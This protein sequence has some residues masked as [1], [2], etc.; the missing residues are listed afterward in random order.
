MNFVNLP[1]IYG[2]DE[3]HWM[4]IWEANDAS[5]LRFEPG[6]WAEPDLHDW[7]A[8][9]DKA[10]KSPDTVLVAHS[11][12]CLLVSHWADRFQTPVRGAILVG[13]PDPDGPNFPKAAS[14][15]KSPPCKTFSFPTMGLVS[16]NDH[17]GSTRFNE[18]VRSKW[19]VPL[20]ELGALGHMNEDS[21]LGSWSQG[22]QLVKAFAAGTTRDE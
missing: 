16:S 20:I 22:Q 21:G 10:I 11:L 12:S 2:S 18:F 4:S 14:S 1:G 7:C 3:T 13:I 8:A 6:S 19:E 5:F 17:Y 9:L 15:F